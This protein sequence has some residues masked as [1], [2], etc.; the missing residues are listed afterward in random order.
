MWRGKYSR[1]SS[2]KL[3]SNCEKGC[4]NPLSFNNT[5]LVNIIFYHYS[6]LL[7][8]LILDVNI[9]VNC[10]SCFVL[11]DLFYRVGEKDTKYV[12]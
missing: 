5:L 10:G 2:Q 6:T 7:R 4:M 8:R 11:F 1:A 12:N 9:E 3:E